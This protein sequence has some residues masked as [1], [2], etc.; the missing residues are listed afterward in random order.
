MFLVCM[1]EPLL[2]PR[3]GST[4]RRFRFV[5]VTPYLVPP[6]MTN[7]Q[8]QHPGPLVSLMHLLFLSGRISSASLALQSCGRSLASST[9]GIC[10]PR[11]VQVAA[12]ASA[13]QR[14]GRRSP[15][16]SQLLPLLPRENKVTMSAS[17]ASG[18]SD[19]HTSSASSNAR[20]ESDAFGEIMVDNTR[21]WGAQTQRSLMNF[22]IGGRESRMPIEVIKGG[23]ALHPWVRVAFKL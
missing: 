13:L 8:T 2:C 20:T 18:S 23:C 15:Q 21:Y 10:F 4:P 11:Q 19:L 9:S 14:V 3:Q 1:C 7:T 17:A 22:P 16:L 12:R 6:S 5:P